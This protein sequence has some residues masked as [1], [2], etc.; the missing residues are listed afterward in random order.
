M[1]IS[2]QT[3]LVILIQQNVLVTSS[4][5]AAAAFTTSS[6]SASPSSRSFLFKRI[7]RTTPSKKPE[8]IFGE[9]GGTLCTHTKTTSPYQ[10]DC[11]SIYSQRD[12]DADNDDN[13]NNNNNNEIS[14][15]ELCTNLKV[16][17][18]DLLYL[19]SN[20]GATNDND[21]DNDKTDNNNNDDDDNDGERGVYLNYAVDKND[22]LLKI[23]LSSCIRDDKP[24]LWYDTYKSIH[25]SD[26]IDM[27]IDNF[28]YNPSKWA[29]RLAASLLDLQLCAD[30]DYY[31]DGG[32]RNNDSQSDND[33]DSVKIG[34]YQWLSMMPDEDILR[35]SLP[36]HWSEDIVPH[37]KCTALELSIDASYFARAEAL[38]DLISA[39]HVEES[40]SLD[41]YT[42]DDNRTAESAVTATKWEKLGIDL[43][44]YDLDKMSSNI[45][46]IVQ[47]RS[48]RAERIDGI[49][50]RP[51]LRILAPIFDFI[52]HGSHR[53]N[54]EGSANAFFG[55]EGGGEEMNDNGNGDDLSLV[56]RASKAIEKN[57][58]VL[59]DYG[60]SS[61][62]A[63]RCL[64]SYGF[65]P[66]YRI[67]SPDDELGEGEEDESVA[68]IFMD[69]ARYEVGSHTVPFEMVEAA[70]ASLLEEQQG[71]RA[72]EEDV[73]E[74]ID[75]GAAALT[76]EVA[77]RIAKRV[78][79]AAFQ[80]LIEPSSGEE[81]SES[82][83]D[84]ATQIAKQLA[85]SLRWSQ[86]QVLL[87]CAVGLRDYAGRESGNR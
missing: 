7:I 34:L 51:S 39:I 45:F 16:T 74:S 30:V 76:P 77:L 47:T 83:Q 60:D 32:N 40:D 31:N 44:E 11:A 14:L 66:N 67:T 48:C 8:P 59:I 62:P 2:P 18:Q 79:D 46:D 12:G 65:V 71:L 29:T 24:P 58:E 9:R 68:E 20:I 36:I 85:A 25:K 87:A 4:L 82:N 64:A 55:L 63:W 43:D 28:H 35:S 57:E 1:K 41:E 10:Q 73:E 37:A 81:G 49:Q 70:S 19:G 42:N 72:F 61:R 26:D 27:D 21:N 3:I 54:G 69:G 80:H 86:H 56:V 13:N 53:H 38:S 50:L 5:T 22:I 17:P 52:N 78:S 33:K 75:N 84:E 23:P 15:K 6:F